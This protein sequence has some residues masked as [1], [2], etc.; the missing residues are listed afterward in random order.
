MK[1]ALALLLIM[2][3]GLAG[4]VTLDLPANANLEADVTETPGIYEMPIGPWREDGMP[5]L[6][7]EG[8][9]S[10]EMSNAMLLSAWQDDWVE[11]PLDDDLFY[12][13]L[14]K[15]I[16]NSRYH[17]TEAE[18]QQDETTVDLSGSFG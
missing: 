9:H 18:D 2:L 13:E 8:I 5:I 7:E 15:R 17:E 12:Q 4:A 10:L 14:D 1:P 11:L 6:S 16:K 3:P